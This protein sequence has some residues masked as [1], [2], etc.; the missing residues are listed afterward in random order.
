M[1][2]DFSIF[3][4]PHSVV[5]FVFAF[6]LFNSVGDAQDS[7]RPPFH[8][9]IF[10]SAKVI[11]EEDPSTFVKLA[12]K[13]QQK[14]RMFD[15]R[16]NGW[17]ANE[18][19]IF[20]ASFSDELT[21]EMQVN[22][23]FGSEEKAR[24]LA[25]EYARVY[26]RLPRCL[27]TDVKTSWIHDGKKLFGGG[28]HNLLVHVDQSKEYESNGILEET[29]VHEATHSS[30]DGTLARDDGWI[31]AQQADMQFISK[32]AL[33]NPEREDVAETFLLW[34]AVRHR[35]DSLTKDQRRLIEET[36]PARLEFLDKQDFD[37]SPLIGSEKN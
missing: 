31:A 26:G 27:R 19:F 35:P 22:S 16:T 15:R 36:I 37:L 23:E 20:L 29:L 24:E 14:R 25:E 10:L 3:R 34:L 11:T 32:Y 21:I 6:S 33:E 8:G 18:P 13:G 2:S 17:I 12:Y 7:K 9:T 1:N 30:L 4:I 28:N 5:L